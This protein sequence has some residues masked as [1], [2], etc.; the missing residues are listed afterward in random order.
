MASSSSSAIVY[1]CLSILLPS[2]L[3][4]H[5]QSIPSADPHEAWTSSMDLETLAQPV[6]LITVEKGWRDAVEETNNRDPKGDKCHL[7]T[8]EVPLM[9]NVFEEFDSVRFNVSFLLVLYTQI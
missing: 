3:T 8:I 5:G 9:E 1:L 4:I 6:A 7:E 2:E